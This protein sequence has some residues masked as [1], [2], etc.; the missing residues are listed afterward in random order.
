ME[1]EIAGSVVICSGLSLA[2][3]YYH[4]VKASAGCALMGSP[5]VSSEGKAFPR[6]APSS[7]ARPQGQ[8][9]LAFKLRENQAARTGEV[10]TQVQ[11]A[12]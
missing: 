4:F 2:G 10:W 11:A 8:L 6:S 1:L 7:A 9:F 3:R 12:E 5:A